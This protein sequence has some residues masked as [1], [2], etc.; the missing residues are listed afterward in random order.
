MTHIWPSAAVRVS[1]AFEDILA[2]VDRPDFRA[3]LRIGLRKRW[4]REEH[5]VLED[6]A[7]PALK[8]DVVLLGE[9]RWYLMGAS[10]AMC[11]LNDA[12]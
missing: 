12:L 3:D 5:G 8:L 2:P 1:R 10:N 9:R 11:A 7:L 4:G 6:V